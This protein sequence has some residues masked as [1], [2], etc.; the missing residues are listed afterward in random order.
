MALLKS[1]GSKKVN[2]DFNKEFI[3]TFSANIESKNVDFINQTLKD[4]HE[5]D[6]ANLI[7]NLNSDTRTKLIEIES[8]NIEPEIFIEL[9]ESIQSEVLQLLSIDSLIKIIKRLES[10][11]A[12][13]ILENLSKQIKE[14]VLEKLPPK[15]K[16]L[17][18]EGLSYPEDSAARIM[19][20][21]FTAVPSNWTVGQTIDYLREDKELP[22]EF[23][24]IFIV[25]NDF[26]PIGTVPSS[27]VLRTSRD[28]KMNSIMS[29]MPV[30]ISVNMD[31]E[32]VG[33][34]FENYNLV[35]AG[36]VNKENKLVGMITADDVVTVV[37]E[38]AEEDTLRLAGVGDEEITDSVMLKTKRRFNWLLLNLFTA[39]L[40]T[41]VISFFG[42]SIEQMVALA[43]LMPIV[44]SMGGNAGMQTLA[45]T[46]R[47]I[48][49]K[50]LSKSNFN[51]VV[52]KEF[53]IGILNGI[54]F[55]IITA[56]IV[57]FWFKDIN[58]SILIGISMILN[59]IVAGLFG[60]L[61]PV[62]L[63]KLNIDP[64]LAS[65]VFVTTITDVIGFLS[66][67]GLGS[68]YFLN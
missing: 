1:T 29:Q 53:L 37:Q 57:Q 67:L 65:S 16:F 39:L 31:K 30:L 10:D 63:K 18:Q 59:M 27:R 19:Q 20:R 14:K 9:N 26:K 13:K 64:A 42:A 15:D 66:F 61:V 55:A 34:A 43:F 48:A 4:L 23:L 49:T 24:E 36:V 12:I 11:N 17:L 33:H 58:L 5:A 7:E 60:I 47:A 6:I 51:R 54:I 28:S 41:W 56:V 32:E 44:A 52:G 38:E 3:N 35:S 68:V 40:A 2:L 8:F 25:D 22:E 21:E 62:S 50:E 45:V 46:I